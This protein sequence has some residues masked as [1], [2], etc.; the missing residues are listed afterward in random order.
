MKKFI[1]LFFLSALFL[2]LAACGS[3]AGTTQTSQDDSF[4][5]SDTTAEETTD[6]LSQYSG[7]DFE[8]ATYTFGTTS[9]AQYPNYVGD[10]LNGESVNDAQYQRDAWV[11]SNYNVSIEYIK[12]D[13]A[14]KLTHS[15]PLRR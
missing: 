6:Y 2:Q 1:T 5:P 13:D 7:T 12:S 15:P 11:E 4:S 14:G 8:G 9:D 10:D 3:A